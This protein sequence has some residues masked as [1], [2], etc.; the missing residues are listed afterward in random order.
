MSDSISHTPTCMGIIMDGN[1]RW[2]RARGLSPVQGH[3]AGVTTLKNVA[4]WA[5]DAGVGT[6]IF[7]TFSTENWKRA[8][9]EVQGLMWLL[10][11]ALRDDFEEM[12]KEGAR[13]RIIG[14]WERFSPTLQKLFEKVERES[15]A[16]TGVTLAFALSYGGRAEILQAVNAFTVEGRTSPVDEVAF[17]E[18]LWTHDLPDPD[19]VVRTGG[20][21][22][23]SGFLP[24]QA[25]YSE[26]FFVDSYWPDFSEEEFKTILADFAARKRNYGK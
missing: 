19:L 5:R 3:E 8:E 25:V 24:W 20:E 9:E 10:E 21:R 11:R 16:N 6:L 12:M 18:K 14:Q 1:R 22:R 23:L 17:C 4:R 15:A 26:L 7:Y 13:I 2:A